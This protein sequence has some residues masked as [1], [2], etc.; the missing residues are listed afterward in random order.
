ML[1]DKVLA[2]N[3]DRLETS[4]ERYWRT[5]KNC[6]VCGLTISSRSK[7]CVPCSRSLLRKHIIPLGLTKTQKSIIRCRNNQ[8]ELR[9]KIFA[10]LGDKCVRCGF[11]DPRALHIDH[12]YNDGWEHRKRNGNYKGRLKEILEDENG[13][14]QILCANCN[15]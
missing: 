9:T 10:K 4:K 15:F 14:Y 12:I 13:R 3:G 11:D 6:P 5:K 2:V 7:T 8:I 1:V